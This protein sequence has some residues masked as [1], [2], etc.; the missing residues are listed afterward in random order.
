MKL[1][2]NGIT[3][4]TGSEPVTFL[5]TPNINTAKIKSDDILDIAKEFEE[6]RDNR[7]GGINNTIG[8]LLPVIIGTVGTGKYTHLIP[9]LSG[10]YDAVKDIK[11]NKKKQK[12]IKKLV[13]PTEF[14]EEIDMLAEAP[15]DLDGYD[16]SPLRQRRVH[17][18]NLVAA[19]INITGVRAKLKDIR[20][21]EPSG[22]EKGKH[23]FFVVGFKN[24]KVI[25]RSEVHAS[26]GRSTAFLKEDKPDNASAD[27][28]MIVWTAFEGRGD[29]VWGRSEVTKVRR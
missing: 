1:E 27:E 17:A 6:I 12:Y 15:D 19:P 9:V 2:I 23:G 26:H 29:A 8:K 7:A 18:G 25:Y 21:R 22:F 3:I 11:A 4:D 5:D 10:I 20:W 28:I 24:K 13:L 16:L 14:N